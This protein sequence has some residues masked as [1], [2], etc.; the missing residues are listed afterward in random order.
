MG[1]VGALALAAGLAFGLGG[2]E[3]AAKIVN[4]W[5]VKIQSAK[6][7]IERAVTVTSDVAAQSIDL[8]S[9]KGGPSRTPN[10]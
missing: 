10:P 9:G 4:D 1:L 3:T 5:Y 7:D 8:R 2:R 6:P